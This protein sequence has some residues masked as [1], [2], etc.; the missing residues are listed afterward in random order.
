MM[1]GIRA[2]VGSIHQQ[3]GA[4]QIL[5]GSGVVNSQRAQQLASEY[6]ISEAYPYQGRLLTGL[7]G[8][9]LSAD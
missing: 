5:L 8:R 1:D 6:G 4:A 3:G 9:P 2:W 7:S